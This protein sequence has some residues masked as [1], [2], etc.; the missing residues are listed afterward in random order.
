MKIKPTDKVSVKVQAES[1]K[2]GGI[3]K[4]RYSGSWESVLNKISENHSYG[5]VVGVDE[6]ADLLSCEDVLDSVIGSNGDGCD[7]IF[8]MVV[9]KGKKKWTVIDEDFEEEVE[10]I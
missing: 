10:C 9:E 5:W 1:Y 8:K 3:D 4:K 2:W 7:F 6:N